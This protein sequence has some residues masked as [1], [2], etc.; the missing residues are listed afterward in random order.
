MT[1]TT[2]QDHL[3]AQ[4]QAASKLNARIALH[5][6][7]GTA[8]VGWQEWVFDQLAL[9]P[10]ARVLELGCGTGRLWVRNGSPVPAG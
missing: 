10:D 9:P 5:Q 8:E 4:Y 3:H 2:D 6:R 7:F 1:H